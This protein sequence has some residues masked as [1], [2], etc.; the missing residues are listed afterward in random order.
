MVDD[1]KPMPKEQTQPG[2][3]KEKRNIAKRPKQP[4]K[5]KPAKK[6]KCEGIEMHSNF[7]SVSIKSHYYES[8]SLCVRVREGVYAV[9]FLTL[10][11]M[12]IFVEN[13]E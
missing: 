11:T 2:T 3:D 7:A 1:K 5:P 12:D 13:L 8:K 9:S 6:R 10:Q 4:A